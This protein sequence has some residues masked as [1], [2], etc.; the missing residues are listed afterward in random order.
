MWQ[1]AKNIH[2]SGKISF[3]SGRNTLLEAFMEKESN[4]ARRRQRDK[5]GDYFQGEEEVQP[6]GGKNPWNFCEELE[7]YPDS[8][9][10]NK[11]DRG[12]QM[13]SL[14]A[15]LQPCSLQ[16]WSGGAEQAEGSGVIAP[17]VTDLAKKKRKRKKVRLTFTHRADASVQTGSRLWFGMLLK[18]SSRH[19]PPM[20]SAPLC[21]SNMPYKSLQCRILSYGLVKTRCYEVTIQ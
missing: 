14:P 8:C 5:Q 1:N 7:G 11:L 3:S 19:V 15:L 4:A 17:P 13:T 10:S 6:P 9:N 20:V 2:H 21:Q 16:T 12:S 18:D